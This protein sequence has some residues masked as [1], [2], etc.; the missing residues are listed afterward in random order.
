LGYGISNS[1]Y[2]LDTVPLSESIK[3]LNATNIY[4]SSMVF[5]EKRVQRQA[6]RQEVSISL[7][8]NKDA[9][10]VA[11]KAKM[12][13]GLSDVYR[14]AYHNSPYWPLYGSGPGQEQIPR[15]WGRQLAL[16]VLSDPKGGA[17]FVAQ[18]KNGQVM[19]SLIAVSFAS[20]LDSH[21]PELRPAIDMLKARF[22]EDTL[23]K[24][25]YVV[26]IT[27][28]PDTQKPKHSKG[29]TRFGAQQM[30]IGTEL[31]TKFEAFIRQNGAIGFLDWTS[32]ENAPM[33]QGMYPKIGITEL[34]G[35]RIGI[36]ANVERANRAR[37]PRWYEEGEKNARYAYKVYV[38]ETSHLES[39]I[40]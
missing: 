29:E 11:G 30:G 12:L 10:A 14:N 18:D 34:P 17:L 3:N 35:G 28:Q 9:N 38:S 26:D 40:K 37:D 15:S 27:I 19:G 13:N 2:L 39:G 36:E 4:W 23:R 25:W 32:S 33:R 6:E 21:T 20:I 31:F 16:D 24:M 22:G 7:F 5:V 8:T 1:A